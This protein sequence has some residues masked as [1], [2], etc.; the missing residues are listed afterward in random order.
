M[1]ANIDVCQWLG[2]VGGTA[3]ASPPA[4]LPVVDPVITPAAAGPPGL[5]GT[6]FACRAPLARAPAKSSPFRIIL[7]VSLNRKGPESRRR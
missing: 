7:T 1:T 6:I 5:A 3:T 2:H 4:G